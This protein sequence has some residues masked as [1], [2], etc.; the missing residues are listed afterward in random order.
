M[1]FF[2]KKWIEFLSALTTL[3]KMRFF[4]LTYDELNGL[5]KRLLLVVR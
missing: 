1:A 3:I 4:V 5:L 2:E